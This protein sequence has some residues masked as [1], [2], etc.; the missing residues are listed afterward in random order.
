VACV[1]VHEAAPAMLLL[2][3]AA[4]IIAPPKSAVAVEGALYR[5][6]AQDAV[7]LGKDGTFERNEVAAF[8]RNI[9][10]SFVVDTNT[11]VIRDKAGH[12]RWAVVQRGP[13]DNDFVAVPNDWGSAERRM[14][15]AGRDFLLLRVR[16]WV[17]P[18]K[19]LFMRFS[20][21]MLFSGTCEVIR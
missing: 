1:R 6:Q 14:A 17:D 15:I 8:W 4:L 11:G 20:L 13:T 2:L 9:Q 10:G 3:S 16:A 12:H 5:C 18:T 7:A 19:V 21:S